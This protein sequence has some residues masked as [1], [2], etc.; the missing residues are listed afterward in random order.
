MQTFYLRFPTEAAWLA[1]AQAAGFWITEEPE[2]PLLYSH[3]HYFDLI[4]PL[5]EG[6]EWDPEAVDPTTGGPVCITPPTLIEG[7]HV[8]ARF[9]GDALPTGWDAFAVTP[10]HPA[11][12]FAGG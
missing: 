8:N 10:A 7:F 12:T 1:A 3:D 6:G 9:T 2:R 4:G 11:R 5:T